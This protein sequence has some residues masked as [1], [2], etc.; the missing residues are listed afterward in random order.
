MKK[1]VYYDSSS[2]TPSWDSDVS[3]SDIFE[4]LSVNMIST[5]HLEDDEEDTFK[6]EELVQLDSNPWIKYLNL[7]GMYALNNTNHPLR[8]K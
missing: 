7:F 5:S 4:S 6:S 2:A 8:I 1:E 3:V